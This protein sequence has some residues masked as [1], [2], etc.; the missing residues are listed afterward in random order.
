MRGGKG[1]SDPVNILDDAATWQLDEAPESVTA[2]RRFVR[3]QLVARGAGKDLDDATLVAAELLANARQHGATPVAVSVSGGDG[4]IRVSVRDASAR[5][6]VRPNPSASNMTGRGIQLVEILSA[7]WGVSVDE[8]GKVVWADFGVTGAGA[9][10]EPLESVE[11]SS[12][13]ER[14]ASMRTEQRYRVVLGEVP[15]DLLIHAKAHMDNLVRELSLAEATRR[16]RSAG[17]FG[18]MI[19]TVVHSFGDARDAIKRQAI[20]AHRRGELQTRLTLHLPLSAA[21]AGE[22]YLAAL[23]E[24]DTYSRAARL[25]TLETPPDHKLFRRWYVEAVV[26]QLRDLA[27]GREPERVTPFADLLVAERCWARPAEDFWFSRPTASTSRCLAP[28]V[29]RAAW[30]MRCVK[31]SST[32]HCRRRPRCG[33]ASR[34]GWS[35]GMRGTATFRRSAGS[36]PRPCRCA[37]CRSR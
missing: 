33:P 23:D 7:R 37:Q 32:P 13:V 31:S 36:R 16:P 35:P 17:E 15:T 27:A 8:R 24:A 1:S 12:G 20:A 4:C 25:L 22:A 29:T 5:T 19:Q 9:T 10:L 2:A 26:R 34:C 11:D 28:W 14:D 30:C 18:A 6:P 3:D 21:E